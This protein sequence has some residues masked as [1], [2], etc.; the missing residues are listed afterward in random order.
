[1]KDA[2]D[3]GGPA[4][5]WIPPSVPV[6]FEWGSCWR[7]TVEYKASE[8]EAEVG[9]WMDCMGFD[10]NVLSP[11]YCMVV[12]PEGAFYLSFVDA[13]GEAV[14][15][16]A[17]RLQFMVHDLDATCSELGDRG[18]TFERRPQ[19]SEPGG[20]TWYATLHTPSG[21]PVDLWGVV[22]NEPPS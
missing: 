11:D 22:Q 6:P 12:G 17:V 5:A 8:F 9:F 10:C 21:L 3:A 4:V 14:A 1:M 16:D 18:I 19:P 2:A 15:T 20:S 13:K 7:H